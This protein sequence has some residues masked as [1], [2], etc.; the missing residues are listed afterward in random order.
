[1]WKQKN[2]ETNEIEEKQ[3]ANSSLNPCVY[4]RMGEKKGDI[5]QIR[6]GEINLTTK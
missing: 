1:M 4:V 5:K 3:T 2:R 6:F